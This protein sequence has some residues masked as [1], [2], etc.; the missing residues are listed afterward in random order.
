MNGATAFDIDTIL[1]KNLG[2][3]PGLIERDLGAQGFAGA[4]FLS[5]LFFLAFVA[6]PLAI[7]WFTGAQTDLTLVGLSVWGTGYLFF[8]SWT[9]KATSVRVRA[10]FGA[11]WRHMETEGWAEGAVAE[12]RRKF[13]NRLP[14]VIAFVASVI[15]LLFTVAALATD[16]NHLAIHLGWLEHPPAG[17]VS[18]LFFNLRIT[19]PDVLAWE[20]IIFGCSYFILYYISARTTYVATFPVSVTRALSG[21]AIEGHYDP[22]QAASVTYCLDISRTVLLF[23]AGISISVATL[24]LF[25]SSLGNFIQIVVSTSMFFSLGVGTAVFIIS[26]QQVRRA[27]RDAVTIKVEKIYPELSQLQDIEKPSEAAERRRAM[28]KEHFDHLTGAKGTTSYV[29]TAASLL[30]PLIGTTVKIIV[31]WAKA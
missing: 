16:K 15:G 22:Q 8:A 1:R 3:A 2:A 9:A 21:A 12:I 24:P 26:E 10:E 31:D 7:G 28:L 29:I 19:D 23:W 6:S 20:W 25:F 11:L 17:S 13:D 14:D 5:I 18:F 27:V 30:L 4:V